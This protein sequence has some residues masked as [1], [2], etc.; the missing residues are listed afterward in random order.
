MSLDIFEAFK[1]RRKTTFIHSL[2]PRTKLAFA[3]IVS[4]LS[5][6]FTEL[7]IL[8]IIFLTMMP[9]IALSKSIKEW[10]KSMKGLLI[11]IS[12]VGLLNFLLADISLVNPLSWTISMVIRITSLVT[13][14]SIFFL[15]VHPDDLS[16]ALIQMKVPFSFAFAM[17]M[18][19]RYV[20]TIAREAQNIR[21]AQMSRGLEL[22]KGNFIQ[23][24]RNFIPIIIPLIVS[25]VR[26]AVSVAESLES[27]G[28]GISKN[29]TYLFPLKMKVRDY[30]VLIILISILI[31]SIVGKFIIGLPSIL[32][33][34]LPL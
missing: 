18:A 31:L 21:E 26:R 30:L 32:T 29:R 1:Y 8:L 19:V 4:V 34:Q 12:I 20:P 9:L 23:K 7:M 16:Q 10:A 2:D 25:S 5:I 24:I 28:F 22:E 11:L 3:L 17:S 15:T 33:W 14:F 6:I 13:A 27:R